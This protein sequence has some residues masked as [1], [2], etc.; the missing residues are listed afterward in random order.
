[1][2]LIG[3]IIVIIGFALKLDT[4]AVV[5]T[6]GIATGLIAHIDIIEILEILGDTFV[7]Q[8][9]MSL[10]LLTLPIVGMCERYGLKDR[11]IEI[12]RN[13][14][15]VSTGR[16]L[17]LYLLIREVAAAISLRLSGHVQ[18]IRP[19]INPMAQ[20]AAI[21]TYGKVDE[22]QEEKIKAASAA[23]ENYGN[24]FGQNVFL[25]NSGVLLIVGTLQ[26]LGYNVDAVQ[27][28][29]W[30]VPVAIIAFILGAIQNHLLDKSLNKNLGKGKE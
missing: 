24:F 1:M 11:A 21:S 5:I 3:I 18:F 26:E 8:R 12:I 19:L 20:G 6:A 2:V 7:K 22:A 9:Q 16:L 29:I 23:M 4:I 27:I 13:L 14:K 30:S 10:F 15:N 28:A 17:T 25:A